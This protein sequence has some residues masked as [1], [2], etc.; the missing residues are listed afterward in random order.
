MPRGV[1]S[2]DSRHTLGEHG[3]ANE[4]DDPSFNLAEYQEDLFAVQ[5]ALKRASVD[6]RERRIVWHDG[7]RLSIEEAAR[8]I[9][10][11]SGV[12]DD[13]VQLHVVSWLQMD[14]EPEGLDEEQMEEFEQLIELWTAPYEDLN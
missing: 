8:K 11:E 6:A 3:M 14:Y 9:R 1:D 12:T 5:D 13:I 7:T 4:P 2:Q 10:S